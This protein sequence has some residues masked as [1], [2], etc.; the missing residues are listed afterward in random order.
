[1]LVKV[2]T[3]GVALTALVIL[4]IGVW[5]SFRQPV[6][7]WGD[8][9][10]LVGMIVL[11]LMLIR[12]ALLYYGLK[13]G[14]NGGSRLQEFARNISPLLLA[15]GIP[16]LLLAAWY[17]F[18]GNAELSSD[19]KP[20]SVI[21]T[22][23]SWWGDEQRVKPL[24]LGAHLEANAKRVDRIDGDLQKLWYPEL[25]IVNCAKEN[26]CNCPADFREVRAQPPDKWDLNEGATGDKIRLCYKQILYQQQS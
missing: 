5:L 13:F 22:I 7:D 17:Q 25:L 8:I 23:K 1:M 6:A 19:F 14:E 10:G 24:A 26:E 4:V 16:G 11:V 12:D 9:G 18:V 2:L 15:I 20:D 3:S 21:Q